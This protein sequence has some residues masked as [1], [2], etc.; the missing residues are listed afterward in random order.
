MHVATI[1]F[2]LER[3]KDMFGMKLEIFIY[4]FSLIT[5]LDKN[6]DIDSASSINPK[7]Q[8]KIVI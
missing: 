6:L 3:S 5:I 8:I 2:M 7:G 1:I 4:F